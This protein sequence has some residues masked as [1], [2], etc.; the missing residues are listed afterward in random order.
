ME[1][2]KC[3]KY[4]IGTRLGYAEIRMMYKKLDKYSPTINQIYTGLT[5]RRL[6]LVWG[7]RKWKRT[8][9]K[10]P[11]KDSKVSRQNQ[12]DRNQL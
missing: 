6:K 1:L 9:K 2:K 5:E 10:I 8:Y 7:R 11:W 12:S 3:T 4:K